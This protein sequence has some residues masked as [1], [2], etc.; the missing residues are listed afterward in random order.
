[1]YRLFADKDRIEKRDI[2]FSKTEKGHNKKEDAALI[3]FVKARAR[4]NDK[5]RGLLLQIPGPAEFVYLD[6]QQTRFSN[7]HLAFFVMV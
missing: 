4:M 5:D 3:P 6:R 1:M 2:S 7:G